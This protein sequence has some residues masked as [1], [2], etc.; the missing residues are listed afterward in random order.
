MVGYLISTQQSTA[1]IVSQVQHDGLISISNIH[2]HPYR[3]PGGSV[4]R[5][6]STVEP[7]EGGGR[8]FYGTSLAMLRRLNYP[9][10]DIRSV[11]HFSV[12]HRHCTHTDLIRQSTG[13]KSERGMRDSCW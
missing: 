8:G 7:N 10:N 12:S 6:D 13:R 4:G 9:C 11:I 5:F 1:I 2:T 3:K